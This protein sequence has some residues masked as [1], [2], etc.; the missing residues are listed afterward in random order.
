MTGLRMQRP[1]IDG[2][3]ALNRWEILVED[4]AIG[5]FPLDDKPDF[6]IEIKD[7]LTPA[8]KRTWKKV[9]LPELIAWFQSLGVLR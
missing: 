8:K 6:T 3:P 7:P 4:P 2:Y 9:T 1:T 5:Y